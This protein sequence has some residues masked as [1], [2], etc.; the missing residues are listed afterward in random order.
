MN[1][2]PLSLERERPRDGLGKRER[3]DS[4]V[5]VS[6]YSANVASPLSADARY[7]SESGGNNHMLRTTLETTH[8]VT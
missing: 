8:E 7:N 4:K 1:N 2:I 3:F 5:V 6:A